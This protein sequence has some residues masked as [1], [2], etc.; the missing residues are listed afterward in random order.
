M[1][2]QLTLQSCTAGTWSI[3]KQATNLSHVFYK[4]FK[5][6]D[7]AISRKNIRLAQPTITSSARKAVENSVADHTIV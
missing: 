2:L 4:T 3:K 5:S 7:T 6:D 1:P